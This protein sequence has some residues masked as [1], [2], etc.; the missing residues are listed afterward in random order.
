MCLL[1]SPSKLLNSS[2]PLLLEK[3]TTPTAREYH[4]IHHHCYYTAIPLPVDES[5]EVRAS[6][7]PDPHSPSTPFAT[8]NRK[9]IHTD[10]NT[11]SQASAQLDAFV[12]SLEFRK[13]VGRSIATEQSKF[14]MEV[15]AFC[16]GLFKA[17][18]VRHR[19]SPAHVRTHARA[20]TQ[21]TPNNGLCR[22]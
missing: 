22:G 7:S 16:L 8:T 17:L 3:T 2:C 4:C 12:S 19:P 13:I 18:P 6:P 10:C 21:T 20:L 1:T 9:P 15:R 14:E 5:I 11:L